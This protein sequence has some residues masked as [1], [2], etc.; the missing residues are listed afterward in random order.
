[1]DY[2][3]TLVFDIEASH[4]ATASKDRT[5]LF[6]GKSFMPSAETGRLLKAWLNAE[7]SPGSV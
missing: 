7:T 5:S 4:I 1:M 6:T 2:E 3:F